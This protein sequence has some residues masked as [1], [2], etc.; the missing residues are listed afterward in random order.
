MEFPAAARIRESTGRK[1]ESTKIRA[2]LL[3]GADLLGGWLAGILISLL[4]F[5]LLG[6][7]MTLLFLASLKVISLLFLFMGE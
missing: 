1:E 5:P 6:L 7:K 2:G 3:Y 4:M